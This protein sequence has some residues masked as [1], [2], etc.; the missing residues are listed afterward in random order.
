MS[1]YQAMEAPKA[2]KAMQDPFYVVK[3]KVQTLK[4]NLTMDF[5]NWKTLLETTNTSTNKEFADLTKTIKDRQKKIKVFVDDLQK[6]IDIVEKKREKFKN[7]DDDELGARKKFVEDVGGF[8]N[9]I[10]DTMNGPK[11]TKKMEKDIRDAMSLKSQPRVDDESVSKESAYVADR[12][13]EQQQLEGKQDLVLEDMSE[14]LSRL[15]NIN[16][17]I[18]DEL[19][20]QKAALEEIDADMDEAQGTMSIVMKKLDKLLGKS[21]TGRLCCIVILFGIVIALFFALI[22]G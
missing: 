17:A 20:E 1:D 4:S 8:V 5:N 18:K 6:T 21:D 7:I 19:H 2:T 12:R 16:V 22:Y 3:E 13:S 10:F 11:T 14:A 15:Q 9:S